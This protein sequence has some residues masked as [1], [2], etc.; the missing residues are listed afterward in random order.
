MRYSAGEAP[1][2]FTAMTF[3][4]LFGGGDETRFAGICRV[5]ARVRPDLLVLQECMDWSP[6]DPRLSALAEAMDVPD[7]ARHVVLG[8]ARP[9][10]S[11][12][13]YHV[14]GF[15]RFP[16]EAARDHVE[17]PE[18]GHALLELEVAA[19]GTRLK[20]LGTHFDAHDEDRRLVEAR[21]LLDR[22]GEGELA[23]RPCLLLGDLNSLSRRDP[24]PED[25]ADLLRRA[26]T[27]KYGDPPRF[28]VMAA[29]EGAGFV[30][31]LRA[32]SAPPAAWVTAPRDRGGVH[33]DYRTDYVLA[34]PSLVPRLRSVE[35]VALTEQES[36]HFPVV[37]RFELDGPA[38]GRAANPR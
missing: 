8:R 20:V 35:V 17:A 1:L 5:V 14:A 25:L 12:H 15:S 33:I 23:S 27:T 4:V 38:T 24:Y 9:R 29:L 22:F 21:Y 34:S 11:G 18:V 26:G 6:R 16:I 32:G 3:N 13:R 31:C 37:A 30:D 10:G 28:E 36:D 19:G 7:E 2:R